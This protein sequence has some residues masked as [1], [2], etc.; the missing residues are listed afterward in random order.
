[1]A[2]IHNDQETSAT[3]EKVYGI[4]AEQLGIDPKSLDLN[5]SLEDFGTDSIDRV[6]IVMK[7][8]EAF[9]KE[10][11]DKDAE[12]MH[13]LNDIIVFLNKS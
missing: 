3:Q 9:N 12:K 8:E 10:I 2:D 6:E 7:L 13:T 1:M 11:S 5:K 4:I